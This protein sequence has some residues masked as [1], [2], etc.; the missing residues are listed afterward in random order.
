V[1]SLDEQAL[2]QF[3]AATPGGSNSCTFFRHRLGEVVVVLDSSH[4]S[5]SGC[6]GSRPA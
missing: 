6:P 3:R 2:L 1:A 4:S 5:S